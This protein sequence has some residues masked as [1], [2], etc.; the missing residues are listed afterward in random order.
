[1][2][3]V[4]ITESD[5]ESTSSTGVNGAGSEEDK[6]GARHNEAPVAIPER[7]KH[8]RFFFS[9][10]L[11][12]LL[13]E[14]TIYRVH[15]DILTANSQF[16]SKKLDKRPDN[17]VYMKV[18]DVTSRDMDALLTVLYDTSF[19]E[20]ELKTAESWESVLRLATLWQ[21]RNI[22]TLAISKLDPLALPLQKLVMARA[23]GVSKWL[24]PSF[25]ALCLRPDPLTVVEGKQLSIEDL[26]SL[27]SAREAIRHKKQVTLIEKDVSSY[28]AA[29]VLDTSQPINTTAPIPKPLVPEVASNPTLLSVSSHGQKPAASNPS[30]AEASMPIRILAS[31]SARDV[32]HLLAAINK[33][34][35]ETAL[36][37]AT[38]DGTTALMNA[39]KD[40]TAIN[41]DRAF[42][43][44]FVDAVL[45][46]G[47]Q[48]PAFIP[49]AAQL[50]RELPGSMCC[51]ESYLNV[52]E[53]LRLRANLAKKTDDAMSRVRS[54]LGDFDLALRHVTVASPNGDPD[55]FF[56][57]LHIGGSP[58]VDELLYDE[59]HANLK[60]LMARLREV[61][62]M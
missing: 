59:R 34:D 18:D 25:T 12:T 43:G 58:Q 10:K 42:A 48:H 24:Q 56:R 7:T 2:S 33:A 52:Q 38:L 36:S 27:V 31:P 54:Q 44:Q 30:I 26:I 23:F 40:F 41:K 53:F 6:D 11:A 14:G 8:P 29:H 35:F 20:Y 5:I 39:V 9:G 19:H 46:Y 62:A 16:W 22:R 51:G 15:E 47:A 3:V 13:V 60:S 1:M 28:V 61:R 37:M 57:V 4:D 17:A 49:I 55:A 45:R 21:F 32:Q 50:L